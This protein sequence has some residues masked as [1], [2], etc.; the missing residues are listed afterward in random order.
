MSWWLYG[1]SAAPVRI[2]GSTSIEATTVDVTTRAPGTVLR[3]MARE[4]QQVRAGSVLAELEPQEAGA[5]VAQ[6]R[7]AVAQAAAQ[8]VQAQQAVVAQQQ[9]T[10]AEVGQATAQ[11]TAAGAGIPQSEAALAIQDRTS[12]EAVTAAEARL[13]AA[14]AKVGSTRSGLATAERDL[15]RQKALFAQG[16]IAA[17]QVDATQAAYDAAVA[18]DRGAGEAVAQAR[19]DLAAAR[20]NLMQVQIQRRAVEAAQ[21]NVARAQAALGN[22]ESGYTVVAQQRQLLAAAEAALAQARANLAYVGLVAGH[23]T[24]VAPRDGVIQTKNVE[25]GEVVPAG[26]ALY[27]LINPTDLW[28]RVYV[29]EDQIGLVK[30]GQPTRT[31]IDTLP[32]DVFTGRVTQVNDGPEFTTVNVQTKE[33]R[34]KLVFGVKVRIADP[35]HR[36]QPGMPAHIEIL[37]NGPQRDGEV[38]H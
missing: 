2:V 11:V 29:R 25:E 30:I 20:A 14:Q 12:R 16:A 24:I 1:Q 17:D 15:A 31:T 26:A 13:S 28:G 23:N 32:G 9:A 18:Q 10:D 21:A 8:V 6:A 36:L 7:A 3:L 5:Q 27:T 33:D 37:T 38:T 34:V 22:A 35:G 19:A 4:G